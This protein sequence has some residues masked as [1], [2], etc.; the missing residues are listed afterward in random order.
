PDEYIERV[1]RVM[2]FADW[3]TYQVL[4]KRHER[5][6]NLLRTRLARFAAMPHIWW[7]VSVENKKHGLPRLEALR[8]APA[9]VRFLSIA[10]AV[11]VGITDIMIRVAVGI[12]LF[13]IVL[14]MIDQP[15]RIKERA[16]VPAYFRRF[17]KCKT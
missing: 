9:A 1:A 6:R 17:T 8:E 12:E 4:T 13:R 11:R 15:W 7:G 5:M 10:P 16:A 14:A 2:E 3:H